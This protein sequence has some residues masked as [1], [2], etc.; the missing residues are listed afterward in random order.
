E[1]DVPIEHKWVTKAVE[2]AQTK[3][4]QRNFDTRKNM[5][6]YDDVMNQQRKSIYALRRQVLSGQ[7][8]SEPTKDER[9][10]G[11]E[12]VPLVEKADPHYHELVA[13][14]LENLCKMASAA[15]LRA[16][17]TPEQRQQWQN[18]ALAAN[19]QKLEHL[20]YQNLEQVIYVNFGC[21]TDLSAYEHDPAGCC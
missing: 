16:D 3:V 19:L 1:E 4:E 2:N 9:E 10:R 21:Q 18:D 7:Y 14:A 6:E 8:R 11:I 15:R 13:Q 17:A 12:P 20:E 5:L